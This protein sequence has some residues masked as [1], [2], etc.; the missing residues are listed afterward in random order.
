MDLRAAMIDAATDATAVTDLV[1]AGDD[2]RVYWIRRDQGSALPALVLR[3]AGGEPDDLD[4]GD[5]A[6]TSQSRVQASCLAESYK[7]A[8]ALAK[9]W[10][11]AMMALAGEE[12]GDFLFWDV[13]RER[14][15]DLGGE[16]VAGRFIHEVSQ[17]VLLRHSPSA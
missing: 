2:A 17:D 15:I 9:A 3:V 5:Q 13:E 7:E 8:R 10:S 14:P 1:G 12:V 16:S 6:D 11:D 4:L